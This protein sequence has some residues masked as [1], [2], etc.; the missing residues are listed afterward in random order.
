MILDGFSVPTPR[1]KNDLKDL[2]ARFGPGVVAEA[3]YVTRQGLALALDGRPIVSTSPLLSV[4]PGTWAR[5][6]AIA[7]T[8]PAELRPNP[9][10]PAVIQELDA[11][12]SGARRDS[13]RRIRREWAHHE[14]GLCGPGCPLRGGR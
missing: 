13:W 1:Q 2:V 9:S 4:G 10:E 11:S 14:A 3:L 7:P 5:C 8:A 6:E 12:V